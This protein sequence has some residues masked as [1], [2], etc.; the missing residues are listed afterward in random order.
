ML[1]VIRRAIR[2]GVP[3][4]HYFNGLWRDNSFVAEH[5]GAA[6]SSDRAALFCAYHGRNF[7]GWAFW[8]AEALRR[9]KITDA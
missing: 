1:T 5:T 8:G 6:R 2:C 3:G 9:Y 4:R 7:E